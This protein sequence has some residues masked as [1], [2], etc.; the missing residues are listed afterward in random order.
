LESPFHLL[1]CNATLFF[2]Q[3][4][5]YEMHPEDPIDAVQQCGCACPGPDAPRPKSSEQDA[6]TQQPINSNH[7]N[8]LPLIGSTLSLKS[9]DEG[10]GTKYSDIKRPPP[11]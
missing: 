2:K 7:V 9:S 3:K 10:S 6:N 5:A 8:L 11:A 1:S 4:T